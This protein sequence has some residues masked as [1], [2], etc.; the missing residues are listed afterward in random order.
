MFYALVGRV[1]YNGKIKR[2]ILID[3]NQNQVSK[4][5]SE[6]M[7]LVHDNNVVNLAPA[8]TEFIAKGMLLRSIPLYDEYNNQISGDNPNLIHQKAMIAIANAVN[9]KEQDKLKNKVNLSKKDEKQQIHDENKLGQ[10][11]S[12]ARNENNNVDHTDIFKKT[13]HETSEAMKIAQKLLRKDEYDNLHIIAKADGIASFK[14]KYC[15]FCGRKLSE[16]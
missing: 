10:E 12:D 9:K 4:T 8:G 15:P 7:H 13:E 5:H 16:E 11:V 1:K 2:Y 14:I 3:E 6:V